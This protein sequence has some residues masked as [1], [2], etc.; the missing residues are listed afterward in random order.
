MQSIILLRRPSFKGRM[1]T[2]R[3]REVLPEK[4]HRLFR[5]LDPRELER[6]LLTQ[7][8]NL[9]TGEGVIGGH[10]AGSDEQDITEFDLGSL[11]LRD[12]FQVG[13]GDGAGLEGVVFFSLLDSPFVIVE[14][15]AT[16][17][18]PVLGPCTDPIYIAFLDTVSAVDIVEC[19][20]VVEFLLFLV[21]EVP[22][23]VPLTGALGVESPDIVIDYPGWFLV[24]VFVESLPTEEG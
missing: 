23:T 1:V 15:Y 9:V 13:Y 7:R 6:L 8:G 3:R 5:L 14:Q 24:Y 2:T 4:L 22:Q 17:Y 20:A 12:G 11:I 16:T 10:I 18:Y 19:H 21:S